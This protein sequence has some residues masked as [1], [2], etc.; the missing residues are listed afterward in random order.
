MGTSYFRHLKIDDEAVLNEFADSVKA[1]SDSTFAL[2]ILEVCLP[3]TKP[4]QTDDSN[5]IL[6][7]FNKRLKAKY[8]ECSDRSLHADLRPRCCIV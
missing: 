7:G 2:P 8:R 5:K 3:Q 6:V 1:G 4:F